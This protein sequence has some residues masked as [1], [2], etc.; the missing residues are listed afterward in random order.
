[1]NYYFTAGGCMSE[2]D[3]FGVFTKKQAYAYEFI[4][5]RMSR[6]RQTYWRDVHYLFFRYETLCVSL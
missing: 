5:P 2:R 1:M 3:A 4:R 6:Y